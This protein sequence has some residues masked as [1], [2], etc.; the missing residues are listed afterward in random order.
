MVEQ[1][2]EEGLFVMTCE[3]VTTMLQLRCQLSPS[4]AVAAV[5]SQ[6]VGQALT[7]LLESVEK[8]TPQFQQKTLPVLKMNRLG[9]VKQFV[10]TRLEELLEI[11]A[12][13]RVQSLTRVG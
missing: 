10:A 1:R 7:S 11:A 9:W 6:P 8:L 12:R 3:L 5:S 4:V 13:V 2:E